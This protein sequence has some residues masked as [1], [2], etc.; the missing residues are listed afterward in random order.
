MRFTS[1]YFLAT[2]LL[3]FSWD[4]VEGSMTLR[5]VDM[6]KHFT[7]SKP[8]RRRIQPSSPWKVAKLENPCLDGAKFHTSARF[9]SCISA[10]EL[11]KNKDCMTPNNK[12]SRKS[13]NRCVPSDRS[14]QGCSCLPN[15]NGVAMWY[16]YIVLCY[17]FMFFTWRC[18]FVQYEI[19]NTATRGCIQTFPDRA[20][21]KIN[22]NKNKHS[23]RSNI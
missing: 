13:I 4:E 16:K 11:N 6:L 3:A 10:S 23:L 8:R 5:N 2:V 17:S 7:V 15:C 1:S 22:N 21:N 19:R 20:H 12:V 9:H 18:T 14:N